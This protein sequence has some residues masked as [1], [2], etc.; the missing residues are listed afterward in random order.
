[1][2]RKRMACFSGC[3]CALAY[4]LGAG[5]QQQMAK[6]PSYRPLE[7]SSFFA[8]GR[9]SRPLVEGT[10]AR[11]HLRI[12]RHLYTGKRG[13][14]GEPARAAAVVGAGAGGGVM[15]LTLAQADQPYVDTFPFPLT[16]AVL[17][18][19]Q[20]RYT[21]FCAVCHG[22]KGNGD[23]IVVQRGFTAPP[24]YHTPRLRSVP[25]GYLFDVATRGY[26]SMPSYA[27]QIPPR[28]RWAIVAY[29]RALQLSQYAPLDDLPPAQREA[30]LAHL[31]GNP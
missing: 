16:R 5:C 9:A 11:G 24:S 13:S 25:A 20:Q 23:G 15:P 3:L 7:D 18:R 30:A 26:G 14:D 31:E 17:E 22:A 29:I 1:M 2:K 27:D 10:V 28:D 12:D 4:A 8:D 21:I 19:G 6:Q